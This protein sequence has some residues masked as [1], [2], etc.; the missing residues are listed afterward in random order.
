M[1][2][3][4]LRQRQRIGGYRLEEV[5]GEGATG[6]V[7]RA[8][9]DSDGTQVALKALRR[10]LVRDQVFRRRFEHEARS[11]AEVRHKHLIPVLTSGREEDLCYL[12]MRYVESRSLADVTR[13][14]GPQA[15]ADV[16]HLAAGLGSGL[17]ALHDAGLV[18]RDVKPSN[19][20][21]DVAGNA[22]LTDFGLAKGRAY[23]ALT[24]PGQALGTLD[25]MAPELVKGEPAS[26]SSDIYALG[27]VIFECLTGAPP[28]AERSF[29]EVGSAHVEEDPPDP[30]GT[31]SDL[32]RGFSWAVLTALAKDPQRRP[33]TA[34]MYAYML[35]LAARA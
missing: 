8:V 26:P 35:R 20:L 31:R 34:T 25:Y 12:V 6:I 19:I 33:T 3:A 1:P 24:R 9:R 13:S 16:V 4:S 11:A 10:E 28:F 7:Y 14:D 23:T 2:G 18:H 29:F 30:R 17:D 5:L 22:L 21:I 15:L 32:S 27:C